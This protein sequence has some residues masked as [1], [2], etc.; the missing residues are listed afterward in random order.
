MESNN[1]PSLSISLLIFSILVLTLTT[2]GS[3]VPESGI[4]VVNSYVP[5][6]FKTMS[7]LDASD[8]QSAMERSPRS[9]HV[10]A[11]YQNPDTRIMTLSFFENLTG[12]YEIAS[13]ILDESIAKGVPPAL[14]FALAYEESGYDPKA[15][16]RN[17]ESVDRGIFQLNSSSFPSLGIAE[18]Y[19]VKT[20]VRLGVAHLAFCLKQGGNEVAA[21]AVYNAG[22]GRVSKGG[23][24]RRTLDY[25]YRI[26]GN[27]DRLEAI[28][29]AQVVA[30]HSDSTSIAAALSS[31]SGL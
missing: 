15:F 13:V 30:R 3:A 12:D 19:D 18:F 16:N 8:F 9:D 23:T 1:G 7:D 11:Y 27:R 14:A 31:S 6:E 10:S 26:T 17:P 5:Y 20:N 4:R 22:L 28:F 2:I 25:I 24:P 29:E 21:L